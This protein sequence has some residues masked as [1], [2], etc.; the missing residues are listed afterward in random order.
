MAVVEKLAA[1]IVMPLAIALTT[2]A[3]ALVTLATAPIE[4]AMLPIEIAV[5]LM[6]RLTDVTV[7]FGIVEFCKARIKLGTSIAAPMLAT[8]VL[9]AAPMLATAV[10]MAALTGP[11][12][13]WNSSAISTSRKV[14]F[15]K[16][17]ELC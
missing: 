9:M 17:A 13:L 11:S 3:T 12:S 14:I 10:F 1:A 15:A 16:A 7:E 8:L 4:L 2:L 6:T 5:E